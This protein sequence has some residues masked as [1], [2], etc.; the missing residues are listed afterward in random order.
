MKYQS[1]YS[2][3]LLLSVAP[4]DLC[5]FH[6]RDHESEVESISKDHPPRDLRQT[7]VAAFLD[8]IGRI[9]ALSPSAPHR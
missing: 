5:H 3:G 7:L 8:F 9:P 6:L 4:D 2:H 1:L